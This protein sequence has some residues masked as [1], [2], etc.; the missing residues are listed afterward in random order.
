M[1]RLIAEISNGQRVV[2]VETEEEFLHYIY[3]EPVRAPREIG[4]SLGFT[5]VLGSEKLKDEREGEELPQE[6]SEEGQE[7]A[8]PMDPSSP[9]SHLG[10]TPSLAVVIPFPNRVRTRA[11]RGDPTPSRSC[12]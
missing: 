4:D 10:D 7:G 5:G 12:L 8:P 9:Y 1:A 11:L 2:Y 3:L 6:W